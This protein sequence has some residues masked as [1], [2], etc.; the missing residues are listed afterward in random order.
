MNPTERERQKGSVRVL[1]IEEL[2]DICP[3]VEAW[4]KDKSL[5]EAYVDGGAQ[6]CVITQSCVEKYGLKS[7]GTSGFCI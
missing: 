7:T 2:P 6:V 5:G 3:I 1:N 4:H